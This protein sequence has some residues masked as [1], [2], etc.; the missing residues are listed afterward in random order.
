MKTYH[1]TIYWLNTTYAC[2][3]LAVDQDGYIYEYDTAPVYRWMA[4]KKMRLSEVMT[5]LKN[6][7]Q[8]ISVKKIEY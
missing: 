3:A 8:I 5:L 2:G 7:K 1:R 6:K 4:K